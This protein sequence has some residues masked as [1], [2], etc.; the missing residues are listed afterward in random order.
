[1]MTEYPAVKRRAFLIIV[2]ALLVALGV[3]RQAGKRSDPYDGYL[4]DDSYSVIRVDT[5]GPAGLAGLKAGDR[6]RSIDGVSVEDTRGRARQDRGRIGQETTLVVETAGESTSDRSMATHSLSFR[7]AAPPADYAPRD[8]AGF[9]I[10]LCFLLCGV[11]AYHKVPSR[12]GRVLAFAGSCLGAT[13]LGTPYFHSYPLRMFTQAVL[14][15]ALIAGFAALFHFMLEFPK[16]KSFLRRK[17]ALKILYG[18]A[19]LLAV[20]LL[21]LV[22]V[23]PR[24]TS[25]LNRWSNILFGLTIVAYFGGAAVAMLHS[26]LRATSLERT[27]YGLHVELAGILAGILP[28]TAEVLLAVLVPGLLLPGSDYYFLSLVFIPIAL[29]LAILRQR[30]ALE[31]V[32]GGI[33]TS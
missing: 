23:Q 12:S 26:Y 33:G 17:H 11:L 9:L 22:L 4:T 15:L 18:P 2:A 8:L 20:F 14:G 19:V 16:P 32:D 1:M 29:F 3:L 27:Q 6:I 31:L 25:N 21:F 28:M 5:G 24:A 13:L 10:G 7:H 30:L